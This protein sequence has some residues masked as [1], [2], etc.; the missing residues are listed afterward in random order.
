MNHAE[1]ENPFSGFRCCLNRSDWTNYYGVTG[2]ITRQV[3]GL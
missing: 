3:L 2:K 1:I